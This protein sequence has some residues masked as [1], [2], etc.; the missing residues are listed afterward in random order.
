[1]PILCGYCGEE[2]KES[3]TIREHFE[4]HGALPITEEEK[5]SP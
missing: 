1:M 5:E 4:K 3:K 2:F